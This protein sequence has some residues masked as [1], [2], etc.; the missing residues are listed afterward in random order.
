MSIRLIY[1]R[2]GTGKSTFILQETK[3]DIE[4]NL[5]KKIYIIVPEQFSYATEKRLLENIGT[6]ASIKA[7]VISFKRLA[8]RVLLEVGG[9]N[10]VN[11]SKAGRTM[12]LEYIMAKNKKDLKFLGKA[13]DTEILLRS[14]T[15]FK[16]H[17]VSVKKIEEQ[18]KKTEDEYLK[19]KLED[20]Y[21]IYSKYQE[22]ILENYI[23]ED[24]I[25]T[26][27]ANKI[28]KSK[29]FDKSKIYIDEF[30]GFTEQEYKIIEK[31]LSKAESV[32]ITICTD[33]LSNKSEP[34]IAIRRWAFDKYRKILK[35][36]EY[37]HPLF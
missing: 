35:N 19:Y 25:L 21:T 2:A 9:I 1:G 34:E 3:N 14:I 6:G 32:N 10:K 28:D 4:K 22:I 24:D 16:K 31:I 18:I 26:I 15:E 12:L 29:M 5:A 23:D 30:S 27:L 8:Y 33:T 17:E 20:L 36:E 37:S 11:L 13:G 7:E